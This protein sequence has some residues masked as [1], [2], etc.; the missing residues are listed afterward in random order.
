MS[1]E[2]VRSAHS[3]SLNDGTR[4]QFEHLTR[5]LAGC[6]TRR[7]SGRVCPYSADGQ[8]PHSWLTADLCGDDDVG[9]R[10][11]AQCLLLAMERT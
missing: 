9:M 2:M 3:E 10:W 8:H 5:Y 1:Q 11:A 6:D 4:V 7:R